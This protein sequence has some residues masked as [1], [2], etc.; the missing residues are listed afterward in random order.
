M[1]RLIDADAFVK[2]LCGISKHY[3]PREIWS[4]WVVMLAIAISQRVDYLQS[5]EDLYKNISAKYSGE[6]LESFCKLNALYFE[7]VEGKQFQDLLG[8]LYMQLDMGNN[9]TGQFFTPYHISQM[10]AGL[11]QEDDIKKDLREKG[12]ASVM[13]PACGGGSL[14]IAMAE[15]LHNDGVQYQKKVI[16]IGQELSFVTAC[17]AYIQMSMNGMPGAIVV[18]DTLHEPFDEDLLNLVVDREKHE[19]VWITPMY[20]SDEITSL[21]FIKTVGRYL[22]DERQRRSD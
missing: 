9:K 19:N 14:L 4:D 5:R 21:R 17:S 7:M 22:R 8:H 3:S 2:E 6:E 15:R 18:G 16:F 1:G 13:D 20:F 12:W 11:Y 10:V